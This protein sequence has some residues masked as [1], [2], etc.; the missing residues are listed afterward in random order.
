MRKNRDTLRSAG[1]IYA[2]PDEM[3]AMVGAAQRAAAEMAP[4]PSVRAMLA[5]RQLRKRA[6]HAP[7][8]LIAADENGMGHC[9]DM[10][11][12]HVLYPDAAIRLRVWRRA[13]RA[14]PITCF[15]AIRDY[16]AFFSGVHIQSMRDRA[17][18]ELGDHDRTQLA[19]LPRRWPDLVADIKAT[20]PAAHLVI[21]RF[22][23]YQALRGRLADR[24]TA[25]E[26]LRA[27][28]RKSMQTPSLAAMATL[29]A[30]AANN[31]D[32]HVPKATFLSVVKNHP[33]TA[34]NPRYHPWSA[35]EAAA[36]TAAYGEDV[37]HLRADPAV[38]FLV[39]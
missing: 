5:A 20:L 15:L 32:G 13:M 34:D 12:T 19:R 39:P 30:V 25:T 22:E 26:G 6:D 11:A 14:H 36:M 29:R 1:V 31:E 2:G 17:I 7:S 37:A 24:I 4:L 35:A 33:V 27:V 18:V 28:E 10:M 21:W 38:E 8:L 16:G 23:D 3:R 9:T